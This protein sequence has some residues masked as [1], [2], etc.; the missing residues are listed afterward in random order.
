MGQQPR[1]LRNYR[2]LRILA[3]S[4]TV[5]LLAGCSMDAIGP[6]AAVPSLRGDTSMT[7]VFKDEPKLRPHTR[8]SAAMLRAHQTY[9]AEGVLIIEGN[10]PA[11]VTLDIANGKLVVTGNVGDDTRIT[12]TQPVESF[13][14]YQDIP[15]DGP[16]TTTVCHE[17]VTV[18]R[19]RFSGGDPAVEIKGTAGSN[20]RIWASGMIR[21]NGR[22]TPNPNIIPILNQ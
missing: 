21:V 2:V 22:E 10:L 17:K 7:Y 1:P 4:C 15:C 20:L 18:T 11:G 9:R 3:L 8:I 12:V 16:A 5:V 14:E 19:R 13:P 6:E